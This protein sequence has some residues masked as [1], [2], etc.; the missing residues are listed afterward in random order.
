MLSHTSQQPATPVLSL[1]R[2]QVGV[3]FLGK[4]R[5]PRSP[6]KHDQAVKQTIRNSLACCSGTIGPGV[7]ELQLG[8]RETRFENGVESFKN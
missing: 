4:P 7:Y 5:I 2:G 6:R 3:A 8:G 1:H